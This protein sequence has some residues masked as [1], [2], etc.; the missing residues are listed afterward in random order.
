MRKPRASLAALKRQS[1]GA[2]LPR[3]ENSDVCSRTLLV[4][5]DSELND[6][7]KSVRVPERPSE[8]WQEFPAQVTRELRRNATGHGQ[9]SSL[10]RRSFL[11]PAFGVGIGVAVACLL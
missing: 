10:H 7:L 2:F 9:T 4:M 3:A 1:P 6:I 8:Y 11:W 5:K